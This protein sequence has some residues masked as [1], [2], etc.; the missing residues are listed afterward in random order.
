M[1]FINNHMHLYQGGEGSMFKM[2]WLWGCVITQ[3]RD[4]C[5][6]TGSQCWKIRPEGS[7]SRGFHVGIRRKGFAALKRILKVAQEDSRNKR[8]ETNCRFPHCP[9]AWITYD[10]TVCLT[11]CTILT[12]FICLKVLWGSHHVCPRWGPS[13]WFTVL[14]VERRWQGPS[15]HQD[16]GSLSL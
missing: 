11:M 3:L 6:N 8:W 2:F 12:H 4:H 14:Y 7:C 16:I 15:W 1:W 10:I 13:G 5:F 9:G